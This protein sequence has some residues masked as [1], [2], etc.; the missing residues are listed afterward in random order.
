M[1]DFCVL[2]RM[3]RLLVLNKFRLCSFINFLELQLGVENSVT[4]PLFVLEV[5]CETR[6]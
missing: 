3:H 5:S 2:E 6:G 4:S 1:H